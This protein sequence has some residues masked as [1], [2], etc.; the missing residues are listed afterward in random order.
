M[1]CCDAVAITKMDEVKYDEKQYLQR[2]DVFEPLLKK[3]SYVCFHPSINSA[4]PS[5]YRVWM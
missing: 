3:C 4:P 5:P 2:I 1:A